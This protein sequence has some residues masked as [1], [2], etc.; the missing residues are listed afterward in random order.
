MKH[1]SP[2]VLLLF[3]VVFCSFHKG[4]RKQPGPKNG[5][6]ASNPFSSMS[7][8]PYH[9]PDFS[10]IKDAD[11]KPALEEGIKIQQKE[12]EKIANNPALPTFENTLVAM[13]KSGQLLTT[14]S[15]VFGLI[16]GANTNDNL[17]K[18][19]EEF[20]PKLTANQDAI[21]L[22]TKLFK[23]IETI[24][25]NRLKLKLDKE[26]NRLAEYMYQQFVLAGANLSEANK[27]AMKKL[28][29]D[30]SLLSAKFSN[31]LVNAAKSGALVISNKEELAGLSSSETDAFQQS[32][33][34]RNLDGKWLLTLQNTTQQPLLQTLADR[35]TRSKLFDASWQRAERGDSNDTRKPDTK[36]SSHKSRKGKANGFCQLCSLEAER[37]NGADTRSC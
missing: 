29:G 15:N 31:Q 21:Y 13:E 30:E 9:A 5:L 37:P 32:A 11:Y 7:T 1:I 14:V 12:I 20:A 26:S 6:P 22:N 3:V 34:A 23:R 28:N 16:T 17:Q 10:K 18:L 33:K 4:S 24:Y 27:E 25:K 36:N 8:L 19:Q 35:N 2:F